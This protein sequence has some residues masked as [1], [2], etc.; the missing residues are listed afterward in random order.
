[1]IKI[2]LI[3]MLSA[4]IGPIIGIGGGLINIPLMRLLGKDL[5]YFVI[6]V[7]IYVSTV[8]L[9][10]AGSLYLK[11]GFGEARH[12][13]IL[14]GPLLVFSFVGSRITA[15][16]GDRGV[17]VLLGLYLLFAAVRLLLFKS[18]TFKLMGHISIV[19]QLVL[20]A[21]VGFFLGLTGIAGASIITG[22]FLLSGYDIKTA[23]SSGV[24][25]AFFSALG[26]M[27]G[28]S[29]DFMLPLTQYLILGGI[30]FIFARLGA[31]ILMRLK[32]TKILE[33]AVA[34]F[35][36]IIGIKMMLGV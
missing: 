9:F 1:M 3:M 4:T 36:I 13:L 7:S 27:I 23:I 32:N 29:M 33:Y 8:T 26:G 5:I 18:K 28:H 15:H 25:A 10:S 11:R 2:Y 31:F 14:G 20:G 34:L 22:I 30:V 6:P 12:S 24:V 17:E 35:F 19:W 16:L 21:A